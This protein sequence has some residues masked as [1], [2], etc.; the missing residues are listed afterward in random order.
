M[1]SRVGL[2]HLNI[3][4][5]IVLKTALLLSFYRKERGTY[6]KDIRKEKVLTVFNLEQMNQGCSRF[7]L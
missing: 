2:V 5:I 7:T 1:V 4:Y 6:I 3:F